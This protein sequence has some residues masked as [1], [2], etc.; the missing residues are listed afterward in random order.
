LVHEETIKKY[1]YLFGV[2]LPPIALLISYAL[3]DA[4][5]SGSEDRVGAAVPRRCRG[6]WLTICHPEKQKRFPLPSGF[7]FQ[8]KTNRQL[9]LD[10]WLG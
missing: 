2:H 4:S 1:C 9:R 5:D 7:A 8:R 6:C 3:S 10:N